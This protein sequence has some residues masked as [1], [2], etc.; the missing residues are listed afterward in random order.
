[1][2]IDV[3]HGTVRTVEFRGAETV[4]KE[5]AA[6]VGDRWQGFWDTCFYSPMALSRWAY[7]DSTMGSLYGLGFVWFLLRLALAILL[8]MVDLVLVAA[9]FLAAVAHTFFGPTARNIVYGVEALLFVFL[10]FTGWAARP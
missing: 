9:T 6:G 7:D 8:G 1:M 5:R 4:I 2:L 3:T 10:A